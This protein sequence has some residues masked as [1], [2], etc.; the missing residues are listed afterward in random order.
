VIRVVT[1]AVASGR[2]RSGGVDDEAGGADHT[3][4]LEVE[5]QR[6]ATSTERST[7]SVY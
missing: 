5:E 1:V 3:V 4:D 6:V 2:G 7:P